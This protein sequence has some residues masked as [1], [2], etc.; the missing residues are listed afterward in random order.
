M[1]N[2]L[3]GSRVKQKI[4]AL[5]KAEFDATAKQYNDAILAVV[6]AFTTKRSKGKN[7]FRE[8]L[9]LKQYN[10]LRNLNVV[11]IDSGDDR[12]V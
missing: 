2:T 12:E 3:K 1:K 6:E 7:E 9:T 4:E 11:R 5:I 8:G 10:A